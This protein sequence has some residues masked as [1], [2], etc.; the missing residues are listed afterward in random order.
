MSTCCFLE[1]DSSYELA[2]SFSFDYYI[3]IERELWALFPETEGKRVNMMQLGLSA[4]LFVD[5]VDD[6]SE[7][8]PGECYVLMAYPDSTLKPLRM[9]MLKFLTLEEYRMCHYTFMKM[10]GRFD[11]ISAVTEKITV[12]LLGNEVLDEIESRLE[13][14]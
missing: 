7:L 2:R 3:E 1:L 14:L 10:I 8:T 4:G 5:V 12:Q 11:G 6:G 9:K 13:D